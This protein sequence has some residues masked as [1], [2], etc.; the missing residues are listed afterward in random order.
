MGRNLSNELIIKKVASKLDM[1]INIVDLVI[2]DTFKN[3]IRVLGNTDISEVEIS[4]FG[5]FRMS[6]PKYRRRIDKQYIILE[7]L[8]QKIEL[9]NS[10]I[11]K[12][13][14]DDLSVLLSKL[15]GVQ[16]SINSLEKKYSK[17]ENRDQEYELT[18]EHLEQ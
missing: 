8:T 13:E 2:K 7:K 11:C 4:G 9:H 1:P 6:K 15:D 5:K 12:L 16:S 10:G 14:P 17:I 3:A 18:E